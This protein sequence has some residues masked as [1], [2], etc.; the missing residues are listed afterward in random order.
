MSHRT[1]TKIGICF[2]SVLFVNSAF[3][4]EQIPTSMPAPEM[5]S[6]DKMTVAIIVQSP[7]EKKSEAANSKSKHPFSD[8]ALT[9]KVKEKFIEEKLFGKEKVAAMTV[10]VKTINSI[11]F[12]T[13]KVS[14]Q[15]QADTA[16]SLAKSVNGVKA[17]RSQIKVKGS[18]R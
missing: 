7:S 2:A 12:L 9:A 16:V 5:K 6:A 17:V 1:F 11:V 18:K 4:E 8:T 14:S 3:A 15:E 13:G 10:H